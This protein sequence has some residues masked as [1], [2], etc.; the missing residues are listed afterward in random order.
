MG[1]GTILREGPTSLLP[2]LITTQTRMEAITTRMMTGVLILTLVTVPAVTSRRPVA[3]AG[4]AR[5]RNDCGSLQQ[6]S[7]TSCTANVSMC[8]HVHIERLKLP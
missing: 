1:I 8:P 7:V 4:G 6:T 3:K 5:K 2:A